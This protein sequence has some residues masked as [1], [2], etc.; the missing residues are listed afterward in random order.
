MALS[1]EPDKK[2]TLHWDS[3]TPG[4]GVRVTSG[5][6]RSYIFEAKIF[7]KTIRTTIG[8]A[9]TWELGQARIEANRLKSQ[10]DAGQDPREIRQQQASDHAARAKENLRRDTTFGE[11]WDTYLQERKPYWSPLHLRDHIKHADPGGGPK[12]RGVGLTKPGPLGPFRKTLLSELNGESVE[13]WLRADAP[14][15]PTRVALSFRL[16]NAFVRWCDDSEVYRGLVP[17]NACLARGVKNAVPRVAAKRGDVLQREQLKPWFVAVEALSNSVASVYLRGL[18][19]TGARR[20]ELASLRWS[21][22][23]FQWRSLRVKDKIE[24]SGGR[25][26]PLTPYLA[27]LLRLL[28]QS[29]ELAAQIH[30]P[31]DN[32]PDLEDW[33]FASSNAADGKIADPRIAHVRALRSAGLPH[34]TLHGLRRSFGTLAEWCDVP[35]GVVAQI[36]GHK[37]SAIAEKHYRRRPLDLLRKWHD[38]IESWILEQ[39]GVSSANTTS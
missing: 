15:R 36:Q 23:D 39:A 14:D 25:V 4:F 6:G 27:D 24:G 38:Q 28:K 30:L 16:L 10:I 7:G 22:V 5:G 20:E 37:P 17:G 18:L 32:K 13:A 8:D 29:Q 3:K 2:Q 31:E 34:T 21:D 33:V 11:A 1:C 19:I 12:K 26:I 9:R 35:I